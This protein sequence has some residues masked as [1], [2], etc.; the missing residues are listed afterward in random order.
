MLFRNFV[1]VF[2][3]FIAPSPGASGQQLIAYYSGNAK[4]ISGYPVNRLN[5]IIFS[6]C[7]MRG[8]RLVVAGRSDTATIRALVA[9]KKKNPSLKILLSLG[10]WGGC[11]TCSA[12]FSSDSGRREF[13]ESVYEM[14]EYFHT[15]GIDLDWE[16]PSMA[17]FPG[18]P[19][20]PDDKLHFNTLI[21]ALRLKL[22]PQMEISV[23]CAGFSPYLEGSLDLPGLVPFVSRINLMTYDLIGSKAHI[24]GHHSSLF[25]TSGQTASADRAVRYLDSLKIPRYKIAIGVALYGRLY[26]VTENQGHGLQQPAQFK[27]FVTDKAI[28]KYYTAA[29]GYITYWDDDAKAAYK[30]SDRKKLFLTYDDEKSV[31]A[32]VSYVKEKGLNGIFFW[33]LRLDKAQGGLTD[34]MADQMKKKH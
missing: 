27:K 34:V 31:R 18:N 2:I 21:K 6:F 25:S 24:A 33:E 4:Q 3:L 10:G 7:Q 5:Q 30:Y 20:L 12:V 16:F 28:R 17:A 32:K 26:Q 19:F 22:G 9:L 8:N 15:D 13:V 1:L 11:K 23:I 29:T 14:N